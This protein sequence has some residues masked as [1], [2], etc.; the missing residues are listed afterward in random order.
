MIWFT[1]DWHLND[2]RI[3]KDFN[4]FFRPFCMLHPEK[5]KEELVD[6]QNKFIIDRINQF[7]KEDDV[8]IHVGDV[9]IDVEGLELM[10][11]IKCKERHLIIGNYDEDKLDSLDPHFTT[12]VES[13]TMGEHNIYLNHYPVNNVERPLFN[14]VGHI[15]GLWKVQRNMMNVGLDAWNFL[16][17]SL[18]TILFTKTAI[19]EHYD[20]NVF[21]K[22]KK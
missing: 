19:E 14:V 21:P 17:V 7:V 16:P 12:M 15:H 13:M 6:I 9:S 20:D 3:T 4:P 22:T 2:D 1:S 10:K 5:S 18:D 11:E 8:L